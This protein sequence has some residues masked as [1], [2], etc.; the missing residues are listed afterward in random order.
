MVFTNGLSPEQIRGREDMARLGRE[1]RASADKLYERLHELREKLLTAPP[2]EKKMIK[3][4]LALLERE[5]Y[6]TRRIGADAETFYLPGHRF[7]PHGNKS[8]MRTGTYLC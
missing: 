5:M 1:Y 3:A 4:R 6:D 7:L 8:A 2:E